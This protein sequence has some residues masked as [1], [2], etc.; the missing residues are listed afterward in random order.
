[1]KNEHKLFVFFS[2]CG[3]IDNSD[4]M[5]KVIIFFAFIM[6]VLVSINFLVVLT[7][8]RQILSLDDELDNVSCIL[9][10]GAG[11]RGNRPSPML[12]DR[13]KVAI[14][15]YNAG[16]SKKIIVSGDHQNDS[17]DE[18]GVMKNYL[19]ENNVLEEDIVV[20]DYG[21][22]T[23]DSI[24]RLGPIFNVGRVAVVS[25]KYHLY[26]SIY[27][28]N[29]LDYNVYGVS[30]SSRIYTKQF[31]REIREFLARIK[32][33]IKVIINPQSKYLGETKFIK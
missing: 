23:Y 28:A 29:K 18:V 11:I 30:A 15:L 4:V 31:N 24:Y 17:Y 16:V 9:V 5:K 13:L 32:D 22:S 26:R 3:K 20:D 1:M 8:R 14:E 6:L 21:I 10:L 27:I 25:Q 2:F 12:E 19:I 33:Y 7:T